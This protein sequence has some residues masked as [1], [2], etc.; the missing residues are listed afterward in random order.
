MET[1][2]LKAKEKRIRI[3]EKTDGT[4]KQSTFDD[5]RMTQVITNLINNAIKFTP[6]KGTITVSSEHTKD[7]VLV[8]VQDTGIGISKKD[9]ERIF[10]PFEQVDSSWSRKYD[11]SGLGLAICKG[12][13]EAH[14]G[15][16][17]V[18]SQ[19]R[20]GTTFTVSLPYKVRL[21]SDNVQIL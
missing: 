8:K 1:M 15:T 19:L 2:Q 18:A 4:I 6:E 7:A 9:L 11:G 5:H 16:I 13:V 14:G 3:T 21:S 12:I 10:L 20:K 17:S